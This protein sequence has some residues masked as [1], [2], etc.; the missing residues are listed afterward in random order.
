MESAY[1]IRKDNLVVKRVQVRRYEREP[2]LGEGNT[3]EEATHKGLTLLNSEVVKRLDI[4][5][6]RVREWSA[7]ITV[8]GIYHQVR[9]SGDTERC[10]WILTVASCSSSCD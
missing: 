6:G 7:L 10:S 4:K 3:I 9:R 8:K 2:Y 5:K 1:A